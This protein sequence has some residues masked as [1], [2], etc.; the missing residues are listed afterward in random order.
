[1]SDSNTSAGPQWFVHAPRTTRPAVR[2]IYFP[3]AG[4]GASA[5]RHWSGGLAEW[6]DVWALQT[7]GHES[8]FREAP[9]VEIR[10]L[11]DCMTDAVTAATAI[12]VPVVYFGHSLGAIVA[13][14]TARAMRR[15]GARVPDLLIASGSTPPHQKVTAPLVSTLSDEDLL[16]EVGMSSGTSP[17]VFA[18]RDL[19]SM[20]LTA[21]RADLEMGEQY[22]YAAEDPLDCPI[23][24]FGGNDDPGVSPAD[25]AQWSVHTRG[26][27]ALQLLA[28]GHFFLHETPE[29]FV[30][31]LQDHLKT[32]RLSLS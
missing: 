13:F 4:A 16:A 27:L 5:A 3:H 23:V 20:I 32:L 18:D 31:L 14:E 15:R 30:G 8:R 29:L 9:F 25:L 19:L 22:D 2:V 24:A 12:D 17:E 11:V 7:P 21:L 28:G 6:V 1:M 10:P 26:E